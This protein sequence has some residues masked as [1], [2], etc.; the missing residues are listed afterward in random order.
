MRIALFSLLLVLMAP[1]MA[2]IYKY[3]DDKGNTVYTNQPPE[4]VSADTVDL[5]PANTVNIKTPEPPPP[6]P[7][8]Q[9]S[10]GQ[11]QPY[12]SLSIGG[13][14]DEQALRANNGTFVVNAQ[15]DPPLRQGHQVRFLLDGEPQGKPSS[16]TVLQLN[17]VDRGTHV[18]EVEVL[19][20]GQVVQ[21]AQ[22]QF[23]VQ[24]VHTSSPAR[25]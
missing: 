14:P 13:I 25:R 5:P 8:E 9:S 16:G 7:N 19:D 18:L 4:G 3:T 10:Q 23:T 6:L 15:L 1:A 17:N 24:R 11:Q 2:Q 12:S 21:R 22:E 20:G